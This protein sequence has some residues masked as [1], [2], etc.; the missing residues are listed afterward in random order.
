MS[1]FTVLVDSREQKPWAFQGYPVATETVTMKT[2]D[3]A[4]AEVCDHDADL[5]TYY[6]RF[7]VERKS[8]QDF[9]D[10]ITTRRENFQAE[11]KRA[12]DWA[13]PLHVVIEA[14]WNTFRYGKDFMRYRKVGFPQIRGTVDAWGEH[15]NVEF[16]FCSNRAAAERKAFDALM[17]EYRRVTYHP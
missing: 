17:T 11:V 4:F 13:H 12:G 14:P 5:D 15:Y 8:G 1:V 3:Y 10:S 2:G 9:I 7:A 16:H 6:P